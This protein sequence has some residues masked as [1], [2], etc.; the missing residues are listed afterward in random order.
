MP[1]IRFKDF[2]SSNGK[3]KIV[4]II[5]S[6]S[7]LSFTQNRKEFCSKLVGVE[8]YLGDMQSLKFSN[9][10]LLCCKMD[11]G[12]KCKKI[13]WIELD[14][15][16]I[17]K[18]QFFLINNKVYFSRDTIIDDP[19]IYVYDDINKVKVKIRRSKTDS[20][21]IKFID[22]R[23]NCDDKLDSLIYLTND[24]IPIKYKN[25]YFIRDGMCSS[26]K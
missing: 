11:R 8:V 25:T 19:Q 14:S 24:I 22:N 16:K 7:L 4:L 20:T 26:R 3:L 21:S 17:E 2:H 23:E 12:L 1:V 6:F 5:F 10:G 18:L 15:C 9:N 13:K